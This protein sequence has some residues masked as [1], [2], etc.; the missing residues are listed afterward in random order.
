MKSRISYRPPQSVRCAGAILFLVLFCS[1]IPILVVVV[2]GTNG[3]AQIFDATTFSAEKKDHSGSGNHSATL[4]SASS[5][6]RKVVFHEARIDR[7]GATIHHMLLAHAFAFQ[8]NKTYGGACAAG[9]KPLEHLQEHLQMIYTL[10]LDHVLKFA[11]PGDDVVTEGAAWMVDR[12]L[13]TRFGSRIWTVEWLE[14]IRAQQ[15]HDPFSSLPRDDV[16]KK[17][18]VVAHIRRGD[19]DPCDPKTRDRYLTNHYY[20]SLLKSY[21]DIDNDVINVFSEQKSIEGWD[22]FRSY[23]LK[24]DQPPTLAWQAM[25]QADILILSKSSF[26]IV[27]ALFNRRGIVVYTPFWVEPLQHWTI[28]DDDTDRAERRAAIRLQHHLCGSRTSI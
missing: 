26:S 28:I 10:G 8:H 15:R 23:D 9:D 21:A 7:S 27:P 2:T 19:V 4:H 5:A 6:R 11:C 3:K 14:H 12:H 24:L 18:L 1:S 16:N 13:Y 25:M 17:R 22:D 20:R